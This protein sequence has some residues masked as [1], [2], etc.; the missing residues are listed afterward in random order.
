MEECIID[1]PEI[2]PEMVTIKEAAKRTDM[3][4]VI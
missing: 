2:I 4:S 3:S 1:T